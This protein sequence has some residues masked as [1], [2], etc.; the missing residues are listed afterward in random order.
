MAAAG[1]AAGPS[2]SKTDL[3]DLYGDLNHTDEVSLRF[4]VF[5]TAA[6]ASMR[7]LHWCV[8]DVKFSAPFEFKCTFLICELI[9]Y[10]DFQSLFE[11]GPIDGFVLRTLQ[12]K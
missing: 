12:L 7:A 4:T 11:W 1:R 5:R 3:I 2:T 6:D 10:S 8:R 9:R